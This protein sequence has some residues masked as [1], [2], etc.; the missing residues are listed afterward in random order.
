MLTDPPTLTRLSVMPFSDTVD[1][2]FFFRT[3]QH[4]RALNRMLYVVRAHRAL[5]LLYGDSGTGKTLVSQ[6][7]MLELRDTYFHPVLVLAYPGMSRMALL[8]QICT[9]LDVVENG[10]YT[11]DWLYAL[12]RCVIDMHRDQKRLVILVDEAHF[13]S[14]E[15]LHLLRTISNLETPAEK[16]VTTILF[17]ETA[18]MRR[19][20]HPSYASLRGR[21]TQEVR[22]EPL[23][24]E[25]TEQYIKFRLLVAGMAPTVFTPEAMQAIY[26]LSRG[27]PREVSKAA[28]NALL[29]ASAD[30]HQ[31]GIGAEF[32]FS[33]GRKGLCA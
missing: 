3:R 14:S 7:L 6:Q 24:A 32:V 28:D 2:R 10:R 25:E 9:D 4:E 26:Q 15:A 13:L 30:R 17:A 27:V 1:P 18:L 31:T 12:E 23:T 16:L 33:G 8:K 22:L 11:T 29:E 5:G 20:S 19:L 21:I